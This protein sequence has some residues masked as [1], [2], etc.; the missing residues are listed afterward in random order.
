MV[1]LLV[2]L[3]LEFVA[4]AKEGSASGI[5]D[6]HRD[7]VRVQ[8]KIDK[9]SIVVPVAP[10]TGTRCRGKAKDCANQDRFKPVR[11]LQYKVAV[12]NMFVDVDLLKN[13]RTFQTVMRKFAM[14]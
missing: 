13:R 11:A 8:Y 1:M 7:I 3:T 5:L 6:S 12:V 9:G 2:L 14:R 10:P 4:N